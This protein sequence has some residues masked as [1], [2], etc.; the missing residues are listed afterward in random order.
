MEFQL[1]HEIFIFAK[2]QKHHRDFSIRQSLQK[3]I[4]GIKFFLRETVKFI[5]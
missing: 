3:L 5:I 4:A 1:F 2:L